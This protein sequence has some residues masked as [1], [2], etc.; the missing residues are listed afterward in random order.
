MRD[1]RIISII[2]RYLAAILSSLGS[3]WIFHAVFMPLTLYSVYFILN[4]FSDVT[5]NGVIF[6]IG[7]HSIALIKAC[8]A[9][10]A[11]FLL[12]LLNMTTPMSLKKR[13]FSLS[14]SIGLFF[15]INTARITILSG[16]F[17]VDFA[18]F[19]LLHLITWHL[20]SALFIILI[21]ILTIR[22]FR[23]K[24]IPFYS[25]FRFLMNLAKK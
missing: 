23:I 20:V 21:W 4:V 8:I 15:L 12:F 11:Y 24:E 1:S 14:F 16:L 6:T 13:L 2:V 22:T 10:S 19:N 18:Y 7:E 5:L 3:L 17:I 25:D 9:S